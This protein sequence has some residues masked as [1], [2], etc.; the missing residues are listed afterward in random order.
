LTPLDLRAQSERMSTVRDPLVTQ[1]VT[2]AA[3]SGWLARLL[4]ARRP[5][6][7]GILNVTP[8]SFSDGGRFLDPDEAVA[9]ARAMVAQGADIIDIGAESTRPYGGA[10]RVSETDER[11]RL[12]TSRAGHWHR[13]L[14]CSMTCGA[15]SATLAWR[16]SRPSTAR[17]S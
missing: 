13:A 14:P 16:R 4:A 17:R 3:P 5:L 8:D 2:D 11:R 12:E 10:A 1:H 6:V 9:Q 15:S 7:M